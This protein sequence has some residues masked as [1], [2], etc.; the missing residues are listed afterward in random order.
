[1]LEFDQKNK[2]SSNKNDKSHLKL[3][4]GLTI[5]IITEISEPISPVTAFIS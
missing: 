5:V 3:R 1:M 2:S 4:S